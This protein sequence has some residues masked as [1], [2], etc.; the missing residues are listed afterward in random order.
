VDAEIQ[1][2]TP[3][4]L[5]SFLDQEEQMLH[6]MVNKVIDS[7]ANVVF[8]QKGIDDIAQHYLA[9]AGVYAARRVKKSDMEKLSRATGAKILTSL[10]EI[11]E[12]DLGKA[13]LVEEK[14]IGDEAMTYVTEC[15]N[16]RSVSII[17]RGGTEHVVDEAERAL[18]D[19]LRVVGVAIEDEKLVA[20][21][22][23][24]EIELAL[25]LR[26]YSATLS[27]REQL[28]VSKF[29]E[30]L[31]VIPRSLA[32]NAGLDPINMIAEMRSQHEKGKKTAGLNVFTGKVV[33][34]LKEGVVEPLRVKTQAITS[35]TE[36][37]TM[38]LRID[39]VLSS[40]A[41]PPM[42]PGGPGGMGGGMGGDFD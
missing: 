11:G 31:E 27:G 25:R 40:K 39:D 41:S 14:K 24:P 6:D 4:Q 8:V 3:D 1:I 10:K 30:A 42:P 26:E 7:G 13:G 36:A 15:H 33:D 18:H 21:G 29:A 20:G 16:P 35:A 28:A 34:M 23:S 37:A 9:K 12:S 5:Q 19:A 38:I 17:L 22:G 32:E 2:K